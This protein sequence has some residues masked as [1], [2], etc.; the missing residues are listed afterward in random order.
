MVTLF[1]DFITVVAVEMGDLLFEGV[2]GLG[3]DFWDGSDLLA[4]DFLE[5]ILNSYKEMYRRKK[6]DR[7]IMIYHMYLYMTLSMSNHSNISNSRVNIY[8]DIYTLTSLS[9]SISTKTDIDFITISIY[10]NL[11]IRHRR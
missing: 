7:Y 4:N 5:P 10:L 6:I 2:L 8:T 9:I 3:F 1:G 11:Y